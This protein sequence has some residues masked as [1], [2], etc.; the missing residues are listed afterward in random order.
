MAKQLSFSSLHT[1]T[2]IYIY[3]YIH[4]C[5]GKSKVLQ[6]FGNVRHNLVVLD[7]FAEVMSRRNH[8]GL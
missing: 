3:I 4:I 5:Y 2:H 7:A 1:H 6:Y 8:D